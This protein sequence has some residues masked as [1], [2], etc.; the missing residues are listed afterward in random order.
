MKI[1]LVLLLLLLSVTACA[2]NLTGSWTLTLAP[3]NRSDSLVLIDNGDRENTDNNI[4]GVYITGGERC[5]IT[6]ANYNDDQ[7]GKDIHLFAQCTNYQLEM[8]SDNIISAGKITGSY[9]TFD[10][11][12]ILAKSTFVME[13]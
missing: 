8:A 6:Y 3:G 5:P 9:Q 1:K 10:S 13:K 4:S 12:K 7:I 11:T 2:Q